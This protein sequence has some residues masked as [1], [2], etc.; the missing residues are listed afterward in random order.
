MT[1]VCKTKH[2]VKLGRVTWKMFVIFPH[3]VW[4]CQVCQTLWQKVGIL[5]LVIKSYIWI[6][7]PLCLHTI[8]SDKLPPQQI[9]PISALRSTVFADTYEHICLCSR[10]SQGSTGTFVCSQSSLLACRLSYMLSWGKSKTRCNNY[11]LLNQWSHL[12]LLQQHQNA[13]LKLYV[14]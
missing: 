12:P 10:R 4:Q 6:Q 8:I 9:Q 3:G 13:A 14:F 7:N 2:L 5:T 11:T 1:F